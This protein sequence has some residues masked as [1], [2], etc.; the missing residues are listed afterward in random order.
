MKIRKNDTVKIMLGKDHGK[1]GKVEKVFTKKGKV[2]VAGMNLVKRH[3]KKGVAGA[4]GS[5][6]EIPKPIYISNV[7]LICP[8]CKKVTRVG[9]KKE[10]DNK[11][12]ICKKCGKEITSSK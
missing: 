7:G 12:R 10:G 6:L 9:F 4:E 11:M 3:V 2:I 8:N 5:I 1:E